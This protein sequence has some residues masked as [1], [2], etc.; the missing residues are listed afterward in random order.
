MRSIAAESAVSC[1][2]DLVRLSVGK[3]VDPFPIDVPSIELNNDYTAQFY[4][5]IS[6]T[7]GLG[8]IKQVGEAAEAAGVSIH[9]I[10]QNPITRAQ[11]DFV[12][13]TEKGTRLSQVKDLCDRISKMSFALNPPLFMPML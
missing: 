8:I 1:S 4:V 12:V 9:A 11:V 2:S 5:R 10:L 6:I 3:T 7:D 13:T